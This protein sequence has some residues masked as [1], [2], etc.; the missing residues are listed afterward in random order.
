MMGEKMRIEH[1]EKWVYLLEASLHKYTLSPT[2]KKLKSPT[3]LNSVFPSVHTHS[4]PFKA[5]LSK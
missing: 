3:S 5:K 4:L 2:F 1:M